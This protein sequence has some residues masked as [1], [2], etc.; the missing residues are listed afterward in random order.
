M[1]ILQQ[2]KEYVTNLFAKHLSPIFVYHNIQHTLTVVN[3]AEMIAKGE[4]LNINEQLIV[5]LAAYFHDTGYII[6]YQQHEQHS[7]I[8]ASRFLRSLEISSSV[9]NEVLKC[10]LATKKTICPQNILEEILRD[11]D[12]VHLSQPD[13]ITKTY[14]VRQELSNIK[15]EMIDEKEYLSDTIYFMEKYAYY[16]RYAKENFKLLKEKN[17][18]IVCNRLAEL[19]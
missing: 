9:I 3:A 10:I 17:V 16:T 6:N 7:Q 12:M 4:Q 5:T 13:F 14:L 19:Y 1:D 15:G 18:Q 8:I 11:A 2:T